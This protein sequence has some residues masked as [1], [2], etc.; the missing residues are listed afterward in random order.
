MTTPYTRTIEVGDDLSEVGRVQEELSNLWENR[1]LPPEMEMAVSLGLEEVLSNVLRHGAA[2]GRSREIRVMFQIDDRGFE[3][4]VSDSASAY[5]PLSR[6]DPNLDLS[7]E[8]RTPGGLG[9]Y[10]VKQFADELAY[11]RRNGRNCLR[12][13]K[14]FPSDSVR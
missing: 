13:R 3:F 6:P 5:D 11:E 10:L 2:D 1:E 7:L 8:E 14:L 4:E 12:F 9:V